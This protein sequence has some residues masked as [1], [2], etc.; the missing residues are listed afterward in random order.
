MACGLSKKK[1]GIVTI[2]GGGGSDSDIRSNISA[3]SLRRTISADMSSKKWLSRNGFCPMKTIS[4]SEELQASVADSQSSSDEESDGGEKESR[5]GFD[6]WAQIQEE[7]KNKKIDEER[8]GQSG[9]WSSIL[10][11]KSEPIKMFPPPYVHPIV[12]RTSSSLSEKSLEI[13]TESLGSETGSDGFSWFPSPETGDAAD[14]KENKHE[15]PPKMVL[16]VKEEEPQG[17]EQGTW[18]A[19]CNTNTMT[20]CKKTC[21]VGSFP[22]P[23]SSLSSQSGKSLRMKTRRRNGRLV[24]E[25][26]SMPSQNNFCARRQDG[27]LVLTFTDPNDQTHR[28]NETEEEE[29]E[30]R[31]SE[32]HWFNEEEEEEEPPNG[33][34]SVHRLAHKPIGIPNRNL[35]WPNKDEPAG[36]SDVSTPALAQ[37]LPP[38]PRV[39]QLVRAAQPPSTVDDTIGAKCFNTYDYYWR[40]TRPIIENKPSSPN[41]TAQFQAQDLVKKPAVSAIISGGGGGGN[42]GWLTGCKDQRRS[43]LFFE[44]FCIA[45]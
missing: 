33:L 42:D 35:R 40:P 3:A 34:V 2:L 23:I 4:S 10:S 21:P 17:D 6:I 12:K 13:C 1:Q 16:G 22:P 29:G 45:T 5:S 24:L 38:R 14:E 15:E 25:A 37:S 30:E 11:Q 18:V 27:R 19:N 39:A 7:K 31:N 26:V 44:T 9:V 41:T 32:I 28:M 36:K 43:L 20:S 8:P